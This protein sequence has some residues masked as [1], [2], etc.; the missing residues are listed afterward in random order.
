MLLFGCVCVCMVCGV[1]CREVIVCICVWCCD[2]LFGIITVGIS[3]LI[4][5]FIFVGCTRGVWRC[6]LTKLLVVCVEVFGVV[7][8]V[9][10][11]SK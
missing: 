5:L 10:C 1:V 11:S 3:F 8:V 9:C 6:V 4:I 7:C 2:S